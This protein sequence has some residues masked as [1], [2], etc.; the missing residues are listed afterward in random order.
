MKVAELITGEFE[1]RNS[2]RG[3]KGHSDDALLF[4]GIDGKTFG[5]RAA[6]HDIAEFSDLV[7]VN[8]VVDAILIFGANEDEGY[9]PV[10][11]EAFFG[12]GLRVVLVIPEDLD[13][14]RERWTASE[15]KAIHVEDYRT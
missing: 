11:H 3:T 4:V 14:L 7:R 2:T 6:D 5:L 12:V 1:K 15:D 13:K 10:G 9:A 8:G